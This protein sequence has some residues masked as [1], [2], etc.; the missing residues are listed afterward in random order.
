[1]ATG[2]SLSAADYALRTTNEKANFS[3]LAR[4]LMRGGHALLREVFD[5]THPPATLPA[6]LGNPIIKKHLQTLR[7]N[8]V[9]FFPEWECLY[10]SSGPGGYGQ[11]ADF[12]ISLLCKLL[13][14]ICNLTA[15]ATGWDNMPNIHDYSL[16]ADIVR[17]RTYRNSIF[18]HNHC[19]EVTDANFQKLWIE[20]SEAL[21]R[22]AC[23]FGRARREEWKKS[24]EK[25]LHD[26]FT[27]DAEKCVKELQLWYREEMDLKREHEKLNK[28]VEQGF[29][30]L[31]GMV[32][33]M[34]SNQQQIEEKLMR[35]HRLCLEQFTAS[36]GKLPITS[37]VEGVH[38]PSESVKTRISI[39][40]KQPPLKGT[41]ILPTSSGVGRLV[42]R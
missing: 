33:R 35:I 14:E 26:P 28:K 32:E 27:P 6:V 16:Q 12:D 20:I 18:S 21:L 19:M 39:A 41:S 13:R 15:P 3:R 23:H 31:G 17:I 36:S 9:L 37:Q 42:R 11:S 5:A 24:I 2:S 7:K 10:N 4:L 25:F 38:S 1:M 22:I 29:E 8:R 40:P 30:N 34:Q